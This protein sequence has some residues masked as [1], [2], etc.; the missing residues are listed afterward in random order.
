MSD[1]IIAQALAGASDTDIVDVGRGAL[2]RAGTTIADALSATGDTLPPVMLIA[3]QHTWTAAG[4]TAAQ[5]LQ[6]AGIQ[7]ADPLIFDAHP[8]LYASLDNATTIAG[9]LTTTDTDNHPTF[10]IAIG[11]GTLNDL[12]KL[13]AHQL[14]R[15]Y[16]VIATAAS[17]DG[18]TGA[19]APISDHGIKTTL[20]CTAPLA[21]IV[22]L[23]ITAAAPPA[24]TA[25]GYGDLAAKIPGGADWILADAAGVEPLDPHVWH[26]VQ[27][28]VHPALA[29]PADLAAGQ[30]EAFT[31]LV[32]GLILSGL[33]MQVYNGTRPA[34]GAEH[35]FSHIW[36]LAH[37]GAETDP[38]LSHG[39]KVAI[40]TL[41][42]LAFYQ[43][44]LTR[45]LTDLNID[46]ALTAWPSWN[47]VEAD[48]RT[49]FTGP[50]ADHAVAETHTKYVN[51]HDL[52]ARL[53]R[54]QT[55]WPTTR[56][57][58]NAQLIDPTDFATQLR[59]AGAPSRPEDIG[60]S[61][62]D[63]KN[64]FPQAMYYRSRYTVLD[65]AREA[66]WFTDILEEVFA[67]GGLW[68]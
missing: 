67:P 50:L 24:M 12:T 41:A 28:G 68:T 18:Y 30:P 15:R 26:L 16:A 20:N 57:R 51:R 6:A 11:S 44:F 32:E 47:S 64:T 3:D 9:T 48:I 5:S 66:G 19:G 55:T 2:D 58:L 10:P 61:P 33:A 43:K 7:L 52:A 40:G 27:T 45:D 8:T 38:P 62:T 17:M 31:G 1:E 36:E 22:D 29:H 21:V 54:L 42:M 39:H 56:T 4:A 60:L 23:D 37:L 49:R 53:T 25:S 34:S 35:Y 46:T 14:G 59:A 63:V 13:A 65:V